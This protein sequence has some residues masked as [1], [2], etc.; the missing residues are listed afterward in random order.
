[1]NIALAVFFA[2]PPKHIGMRESLMRG[3]TK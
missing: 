3:A 1:V 2:I